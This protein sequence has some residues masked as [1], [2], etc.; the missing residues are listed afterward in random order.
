MQVVA[1]CRNFDRCQRVVG[2]VGTWRA[3]PRLCR[4]FE[5]AVAMTIVTADQVAG[6]TAPL[7]ACH[8][9][10][11]FQRS[12][13]CCGIALYSR[14]A[15]ATNRVLEPSR[16]LWQLRSIALLFDPR[17]QAIYNAGDR[18]LLEAHRVCHWCTDAFGCHT[19]VHLGQNRERF[20]V[21]SCDQ[22][23][24]FHLTNDTPPRLL[25]LGNLEV[26]LGLCSASHIENKQ[27]FG[28]Q[29]VIQ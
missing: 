14:M 26:Q 24:R 21:V 18:F 2:I 4:C 19:K 27:M 12:A 10:I 5:T 13:H 15:H 22:I 1:T 29:V 23:H 28:Q 20:V 11:L 8:K 17:L 3:G 25:E 7:L 6:L 9:A 16:S